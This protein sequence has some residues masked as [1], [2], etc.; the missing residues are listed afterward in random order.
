MVR[1]YQ[2]QIMS[3]QQSRFEKGR[4]T[5]AQFDPTSYDRVMQTW[6]DFSPELARFIIEYPYGDVLSRP[7]L[8]VKSRALAIVAALTALGNAGPQLKVHINNA[9][10]LG[11]TPQEIIELMLQMTVYAGFPAGINGMAVAREVIEAREGD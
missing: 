3:D 1:V 6:G 11:W 5:L 2:E 4:E 8:D 9:L 10:N 7:G